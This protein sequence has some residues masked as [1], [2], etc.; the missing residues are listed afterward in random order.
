MN[1]LFIIKFIKVEIVKKLMHHDDLL[2]IEKRVIFQNLIL[3]YDN[4]KALKF[5]VVLK[6]I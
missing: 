6:K 1:E 2:N 5:E 4:Q 3:Q